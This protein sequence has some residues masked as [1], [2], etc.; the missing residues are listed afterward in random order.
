MVKSPSK[1]FAEFDKH[2]NLEVRMLLEYSQRKKEMEGEDGEG[3]EVD[4]LRH[5]GF[6][7][8]LGSEKC[9]AHSV[10][11]VRSG[12]RSRDWVCTLL[13]LFT[14]CTHRCKGTRRATKAAQRRS[15]WRRVERAPGTG[16][17]QRGLQPG[18]GQWSTMLIIEYRELTTTLQLI[19]SRVLAEP[20]PSGTG[21]KAKASSGTR[22]RKATEVQRSHKVLYSTSRA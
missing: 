20:S 4:V 2:R 11:K 8:S 21:G 22:I 9:H 19:K 17:S 12:E 7:N 14:A 10:P 3:D 15:K 5:Q 18:F 16:T 13:C 6:T 1:L